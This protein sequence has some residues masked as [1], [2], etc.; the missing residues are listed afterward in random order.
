M[1]RELL[2][3]RGMSSEVRRNRSWGAVLAAG[4]VA[5]VLVPLLMGGCG[6]GD[7]IQREFRAAA[8]GGV[9]SGVRSIVDGQ[10]EEG[11]RQIVD[12][13][14]DGIFTVA[15]PKAGGSAHSGF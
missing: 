3:C 15:D 10:G 5:A 1:S 9:E 13:I 11:I 4:V 7:D 2:S 14:L 8:V 6:F 12:G